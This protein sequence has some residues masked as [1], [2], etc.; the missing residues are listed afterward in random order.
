[1]LRGPIKHLTQN[2]ELKLLSLISAILLW[3]FVVSREKTEGVLSAAVVFEN[4]PKGLRMIG[5]PP[6]GV[7]VKVR[8]LRTQLARLRSEGLMARVD[9]S[10]SREGENTL[11]LLSE[12]LVTPPRVRVL[13]I[14]PSRLQVLLE[15]GAP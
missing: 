7:E 5:Q 9:L 3:G 2:W 11:L 10:G 1:M 6:E 14:S 12:H 15:K 4:L 8:G 13:R